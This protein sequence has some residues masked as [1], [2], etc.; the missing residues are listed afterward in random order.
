MSKADRRASRVTGARVFA[1]HKSETADGRYHEVLWALDGNLNAAQKRGNIKR[2]RLWSRARN[3]ANQ[4]AKQ[5]GC[6]P[7]FS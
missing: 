1:V 5:L 2:F 3:F 4:K 7:I 6:K